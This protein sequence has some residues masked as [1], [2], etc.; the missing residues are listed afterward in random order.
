M[1]RLDPWLD[2]PTVHDLPRLNASFLARHGLGCEGSRAKAFD[3][4]GVKVIIRTIHDCV[5]SICTFW[6]LDIYIQDVE[7]VEFWRGNIRVPAFICPVKKKT[8][9]DLY[10]NGQIWA[11]RK[12]YPFK[13]PQDDVARGRALR[14]NYDNV[15]GLE[16]L[17]PSTGKRR[18]R[19]LEVLR[20]ELDRLELVPNF[21]WG[22]GKVLNQVA[23]DEQAS[24]RRPLRAPRQAA[25]TL[26]WA[27]ENGW[28]AHGELP[29]FGSGPLSPAGKMQ[30][31]MQEAD[32]STE[33]L[34]DF[35]AIDLATI[36]KRGWLS[37]AKRIWDLGWAPKVTGGSYLKLVVDPSDPERPQLRIE[38]SGGDLIRPVQQRIEVVGRPNMPGRW[39]LKCPVKD[40]LHARLFLRDGFFASASAQRLVHRSKRI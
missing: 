9:T 26:A 16:G 38:F 27:I 17:Q 30:R 35:V 11:S 22:I 15:L 33:T 2:W 8:V 34:E 24:R 32:R 25:H 5:I 37:G 39:F 6:L 7:I 23:E 18:A 10:F 29:V 12:A 21:W 20:E 31:C 19:Q 13:A 14:I 4:Y 1:L 36:Q 28:A 3:T 40:T